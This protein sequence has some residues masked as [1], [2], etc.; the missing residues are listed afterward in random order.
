M[1]GNK[2]VILKGDLLYLWGWISV[3]TSDRIHGLAGGR[4]MRQSDTLG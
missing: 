4:N 2:W 3:G 1:T